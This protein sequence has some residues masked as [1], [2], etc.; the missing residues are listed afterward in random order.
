MENRNSGDKEKRQGYTDIHSHLFPGVDDGAQ[1]MEMSMA[2]FRIAWENGIRCMILTPHNKPA[3]RNISQR[4]LGRGLEELQQAV[5][6]QGMDIELFPGSEVYYRSDAAELLEQG[7][8]PTMAGSSYVLVEFS[9][10]DEF[11]YIRNGIYH[12]M[13]GGYRPIL[14]HAER[15]KCISSSIGRAEE[16]ERMGCCIQVN[17]DS[18]MGANGWHIKRFTRS[19]LK[20]RMVHFVATDAH[21][22]SRRAPYL[23]N[24]AKYI[25]RHFGEDYVMRLLQVNPSRIIADE[26]I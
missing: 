11:D 5:R 4:S 8:I 25:G 22:D 10:M 26:Y 18:I 23:M 21:N 1:S 19:L 7:E 15:Y 17:A 16:L 20:K 3:R 9:P 14:A 13:A 12:L 24:C 2:M 6:A